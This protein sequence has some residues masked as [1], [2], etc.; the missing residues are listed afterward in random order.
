L[1]SISRIQR[2][3]SKLQKIIEALNL[4]ALLVAS[5]SNVRYLTGFTGSNGLCVITHKGASFL[6]DFRYQQQS[7]EEVRGCEIF[8]SRSNLFE[9]LK[10]KRLL[11]RKNHIGFESHLITHDQL[12]RLQKLFPKKEWKP[13]KDLI[14]SIASVKDGDELEFIRKAVYITDIVYREILPLL[15]PGVVEQDIAAEISYRCRRYGADNDAFSSIVASGVRSAMPHGITSRKKIATGELLTLD[16]GCTFN[17][18]GSDMTRTVSIGQPS[19]K[20]KLVHQIVL[21]A[22]LRAI[23]A[24]KPGMSCKSLDAVA[25]NFIKGKG[26]GRYFSHALGHGLGL[27]SHGKPLISALSKNCSLEKGNVFTVEPGIYIP[28]QFG[29]RIED[30]IVLTDTGCEVLTRSPKELIVL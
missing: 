25:R 16:F 14:E 6:T 7:K 15:K 29:V 22:Q 4:D 19:R 17:G 30:N 11:S 12:G 20:A 28:G 10:E 8:V 23:D 3:V 1:N 21:E 26:Y 24:A 13:I 2:R 5:K 9:T 27:P 18:Y